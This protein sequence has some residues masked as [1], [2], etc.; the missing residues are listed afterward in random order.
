SE[1]SAWE[2]DRNNSTKN[3]QWHFT[4]DNARGKL[5]WLYPKI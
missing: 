3:V 4:T 1:V 5:K 2:K